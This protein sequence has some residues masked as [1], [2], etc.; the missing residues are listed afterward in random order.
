MPYKWKAQKQG[1]FPFVPIEA[2]ATESTED[3][4]SDTQYPSIGNIQCD[5]MWI[6]R[7]AVPSRVCAFCKPA[8]GFQHRFFCSF[9]TTSCHPFVTCWGGREPT[10]QR[11]ETLKKKDFLPTDSTEQ[12]SLHTLYIMQGF[13]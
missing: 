5:K 13:I 2:R 8:E 3:A 11:A 10:E 9:L 6:W 1:Q 12:N 4:R 7:V